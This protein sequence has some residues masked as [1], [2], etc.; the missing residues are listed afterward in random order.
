MRELY[1]RVPEGENVDY[2]QSDTALIIA[3]LIIL[4]KDGADNMLILALIYILT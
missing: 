4:I 2:R 1:G 3:L